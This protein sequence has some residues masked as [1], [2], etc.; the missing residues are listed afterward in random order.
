MMG[1]SFRILSSIKADLLHR[2]F[3]SDNLYLSELI[4]ILFM[5]VHVCILEPATMLRYR[6]ISQFRCLC[7]FMVIHGCILFHGGKIVRCTSLVCFVHRLVPERPAKRR[8]ALRVEERHAVRRM[9]TVQ[10]LRTFEEHDGHSRLLAEI[11]NAL[12]YLR[13]LLGRDKLDLFENLGESFLAAGGELLFL[14]FIFQTSLVF[15]LF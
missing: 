10:V 14:H 7:L 9:K 11:R 3:T 5:F 15:C 13:Q 4:I 8:L 6:Y 2:T 12:L 1:G